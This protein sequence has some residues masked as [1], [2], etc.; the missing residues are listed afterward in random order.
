ML[1][2]WSQVMPIAMPA[3]GRT[4][5]AHHDH[6]VHPRR[7]QLFVRAVDVP[8]ATPHQVAVNRSSE[9]FLRGG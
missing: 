6:N 3:L 7:P 5:R 2:A 8:H 1:H 9:D 4:R